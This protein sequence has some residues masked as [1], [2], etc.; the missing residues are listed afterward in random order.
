[1][2]NAKARHRRRYRAQAASWR[3]WQA[4]GGV[5]GWLAL[6][7]A[8]SDDLHYASTRRGAFLSAF[9]GEHINGARFSYDTPLD[10]GAIDAGRWCSYDRG[11]A[12]AYGD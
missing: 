3:R 5:T 1:M 12:E 4:L 9:A 10:P 11:G 6:M 2:S 8:V 7:Y